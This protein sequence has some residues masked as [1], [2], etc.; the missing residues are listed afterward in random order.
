MR[1]LCLHASYACHSQT[2]RSVRVCMSVFS[3]TRVCR[4]RVGLKS[5]LR[6][7]PHGRLSAGPVAALL[8]G[9]LRDLELAVRPLLAIL[10]RVAAHCFAL[11]ERNLVSRFRLRHGDLV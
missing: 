6:S 3:P 8:G 4:L 7:D 1:P 11:L 9:A 5:D 2:P 10:L